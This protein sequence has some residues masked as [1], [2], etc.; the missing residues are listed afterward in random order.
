MTCKR[1]FFCLQRTWFCSSWVLCWPS[2]EN[3]GDRG[4]HRP[5]ASVRQVL[6]SCHFSSPVCMG[7]CLQAFIGWKH[8]YTGS[9]C[10]VN[11]L[12]SLWKTLE[13]ILLSELFSFLL[14]ESYRRKTIA[15]FSLYVLWAAKYQQERWK[16][17]QPRASQSNREIVTVGASCQKTRVV[18][19][20]LR[21][22]PIF[23]LWGD[24]V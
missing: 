23:L 9:L 22:P 6:S 8:T 19:R 24:G 15:H 12:P 11:M 3:H 21:M 14:S 16:T 2:I 13:P 18:Y 17:N 20:I 10:C 4:P 1:W 7:E 5:S